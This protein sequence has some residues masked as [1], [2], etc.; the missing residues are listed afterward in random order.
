MA[1]R[2]RHLRGRTGFR[3]ALAGSKEGS[4]QSGGVGEQELGEP[5]VR[6]RLGRSVDGQL[7]EAAALLGVQGQVRGEL[8][9]V[10]FRH[11]D[12]GEP[13]TGERRL[14]VHAE[15]LGGEPAL[16]H[17]RVAAQLGGVQEHAGRVAL[18]RALLE[19]LVPKVLA[20][21]RVLVP[22]DPGPALGLVGPPGGEV[23]D[24]HPVQQR[25]LVDHRVAPS[26]AQVAPPPRVMKSAPRTGAARGRDEEP[27]EVVLPVSRQ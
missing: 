12:R 13:R 1:H 2:R 27:P 11:L 5:E 17:A 23:D 4:A 14:S 9:E 26:E 8:L 10:R 25:A 6:V 15:H 18:E 21:G 24:P 20:R 22:E 3:V 7:E 19:P 16:G